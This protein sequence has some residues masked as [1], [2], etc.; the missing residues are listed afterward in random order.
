MPFLEQEEKESDGLY[1]RLK[2]SLG[3]DKLPWSTTPSVLDILRLDELARFLESKF[4]EMNGL[5]EIS[6]K[7]YEERIAGFRNQLWLL[8]RQQPPFA[9]MVGKSNQV[10]FRPS[11]ARTREL[12]PKGLGPFDPG[13]HNPGGP[14]D[15]RGPHPGGPD[16]R[17][18]DPR[19][20]R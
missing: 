6:Y 18:P 10:L 7:D 15:P 9:P 8:L 12:Y 13:P 16:P 2:A 19:G 11:Y 20:P 14:G 4:R 3:L 17:G 5:D 1:N